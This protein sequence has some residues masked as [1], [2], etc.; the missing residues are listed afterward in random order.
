MPKSNCPVYIIKHNSVLKVCIE[1]N[2]TR[3]RERSSFVLSFTQKLWRHRAVYGAQPTFYLWFFYTERLYFGSFST[4]LIDRPF[5]VIA[6]IQG[7]VLRFVN[8]L[9][10]CWITKLVSVVII[11]R[12]RTDRL[13]YLPEQAQRVLC[14]R[15]CLRS[16]MH[17]FTNPDDTIWNT[18]IRIPT[19]IIW[20][21]PPDPP[22]ILWESGSCNSSLF[23]IATLYR[24]RNIN[25]RG[26]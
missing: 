9:D 25:S 23:G 10:F 22:A 4:S 20:K 24:R 6:N 13:V 3:V 16:W 1:L 18:V 19:G 11:C 17:S 14:R 5:F 12:L 8:Y 2:Q 7:T 26:T 21:K 15:V